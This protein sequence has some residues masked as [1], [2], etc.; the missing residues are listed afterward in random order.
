MTVF[1]CILLVLSGSFPDF[2]PPP[3]GTGDEILPLTPRAFGMGGV[4][5][6]VPDSTS[7]S[8]LNPAASAWSLNSGVCFGGRYSEGDVPAWDNSLGFPLISAIVPL[9]GR[10]VVT[11]AID[12]K[13]RLNTAEEIIL[14]DFTGDLSWAGGRVESYA[15]LS[16]RAADWLA[17]SF[18]GRCTFGSIVSDVTLIPDAPDYP[19]KEIEYRD[20]VSFRQ[21]WG[22][23]FGLFV[24][25]DRF[26]L[27]F[28]IS[29]DRKGILDIHRDYVY[30]DPDSSSQMYTIPGELSA[31]ISFRPLDRL[32]IG[33]DIFSRKS[34]D[35]LDSH[36]DSGTIISAGSEVYIGS[37]LIARTGYSHMNG[38]WRDG[39]DRFT[40][41]AG[42][43]F[44]NGSAGI[45]LSTGYQFWRNIQDE[46]QKETVIFISLWA[47]EKWLG[48]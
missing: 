25:A 23:V 36:T 42:L 37:G 12:G 14:D 44:G 41:G 8:M 20:D 15:G 18:G 11:A 13:S 27:G 34:L 26:G 6:G 46:F 5:A 48:E 1:T 7:F 10:I 31:G 40:V 16:G 28:S 3:T 35:V 24:N 39:A 21:A 33:L 30:Y 22:G 19:T 29:T 45:D 4:C 38:L 47:T 32:L 43:V 17:F 9:P 2:I